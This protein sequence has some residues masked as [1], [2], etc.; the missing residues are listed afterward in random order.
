[1]RRSI[2]HRGTLPAV[3]P[4]FASCIRPNQKQNRAQHQSYNVDNGHGRERQRSDNR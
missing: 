3:D 4:V 1:M 2:K